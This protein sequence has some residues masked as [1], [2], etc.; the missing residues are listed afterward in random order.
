MSL[1]VNIVTVKADHHLLSSCLSK[2]VWLPI[3]CLKE[4]VPKSRHIL[5]NLPLTNV[6]GV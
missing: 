1:C 6:V 4:N 5:P 3:P 2:P